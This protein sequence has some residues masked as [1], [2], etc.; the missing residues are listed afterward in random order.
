MRKIKTRIFLTALIFLILG[1]VT[2]FA[3]EIFNYPQGSYTDSIFLS[4]NDAANKK[5]IFYSFTA[6]DSAPDMPYNGGFLLS[7]LP[8]EER[9]YTLSLKISGSVYHFSYKIDRKAPLPPVKE[10]KTLDSETG[11]IFKTADRE[12]VHIYYGYDDYKS[13]QRLEWKGELIKPNA[14]SYI[15]Y[16]AEDNAGNRSTVETIMPAG[17]FSRSGRLTLNVKSPVEGVFLNTQLLFI[18]REGFEWIKYSLNGNDPLN[19]GADYTEPV[20]IRRYGTVDLKIAAKPL[21]SDQIITKDIE[22]R[23][24][25]RSPLKNIPPSGIYSTGIN[26]PGMFDSYKYCLEERTPGDSD[27][28]LK[29]S[30]TINPVYGGVKYTI[31]R[32]ND[33]QDKTEGDYRY[34]YVIDER[35]P[36]NPIITFKSRLPDEKKLDVEISGPLYSDIYYTVDGSSPGITSNLFKKTFTIDIPDNKN[37]GSIILK[38]RAISLNGKPSSVVSKIFTY[39]TQ[40][41]DTPKVEFIQNPANGIYNIDYTIGADEQLYYFV[42]RSSEIVIPQK[43]DFSPVEKERFFIDIPEGDSGKFNF[44]FAVKDSAGNWSKFSDPVE[45]KIDKSC[46]VLPEVNY[47]NG[48]LTFDDSAYPEKYSYNLIIERNGE[49]LDNREGDWSGSLSVNES[50]FSYATLLLKLECSDLYGNTSYKKYKFYITG[51]KANKETVLFAGKS[52]NIFSGREVNFTAY[53]DGVNDS[54][55]YE[56]TVLT[57]AGDD[58]TTGPIETDGRITIEGT[59]NA[60][61]DYRLDVYSLNNIDGTKSKISSYKFTIDNEKPEVPSFKGP[62]NNSIISDRVILEA[63]SDGSSTVFL[64]VGNEQDSVLNFS[65]QS[66]VFNKPL[67]FDVKNGKEKDFSL[68]ISAGDSA[69]NYVTNDNILAFTIDKKPPVI[70]EAM[71]SDETAGNNIQKLLKLKSSE[72]CTYYYEIGPAGSRISSPDT[73]SEY[74]TDSL[75]LNPADRKDGS[76]IIKVLPIDQAGNAADYPLSFYYNISRKK[77]SNNLS[78]VTINNKNTGKIYITFPS[79]KNNSL[80]YRINSSGSESEWTAYE[81]PFSVKYT[82][83]TD[84]VNIEYYLSD[85]ANNRSAVKNKIIDLPKENNSSLVSGIDNNGFYRE[86]LQLQSA[87]PRSGKI[88]RYEISTDHLLPNEVSVFSPELPETLPFRI[89]N[90]ESINFIVSIKE[91]EN[92]DDVTGGATQVLRF[93]IDKQLPEPPVISGISDGEYYLEDCTAYFKPTNDKIFYTVSTGNESEEEYKVFSQPFLISTPAGTYFSYKIKAFTQDLSGNRS[94]TKTWEITIDKEIIYVSEDGK[95]YFE[96]TRSRPFASI[97]KALEQV[98][99]SKRKTIFIQEGNYRLNSPGVIDENITLYGGFK[100]GSWQNKT[101][102]TYINIESA[103]PEDNPAFYIYGGNLTVENINFSISKETSGTVFFVNKG[104]LGIRNCNIVIDSGSLMSFLKQ[105]YGKLVLSNSSFSGTIDGQPLLYNEYGEIDINNSKFNF[106][107]NN[108]FSTLIKAE[109]CLSYNLSSTEFNISK[110]RDFTVLSFLN[111]AVKLKSDTIDIRGCGV[112]ATAIEGVGSKINVDYSKFLFDDS[113]RQS[114]AV[115]TEDCLFNFSGNTVN[116]DA[117]T[118]IIGFNLTGGESYIAENKVNCAE[119]KDFTYLYIL[120]KGKHKIETNLFNIKP[121]NEMLN[122]RTKNAQADYINNTFVFT[123]SGKSSVVF[124]PEANSMT[125]IINNIIFNSNP[126]PSGTLVYSDTKNNL[127]LKNNCLY[128]WS[129]YYSGIM[130][131][132]TLIKLDLLDGIYSGGNFSANIEEQPAVTFQ[133][134]SLY[135]LSADSKCINSGY[136]VTNIIKDNTDIDGEQRPNR[137]LNIINA[138]DIGA[139]EYY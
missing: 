113:N 81:H 73:D 57:P 13:G 76:Y 22:Y 53:P 56:L 116:L 26:I 50:D 65:N 95:D 107:S 31:L 70:E 37:A 39:D 112:G 138:Y 33:T 134:D 128:G 34:F 17:E 98:K 51:K 66:I 120:N 42:N 23:V 99:L 41:P 32:L 114:R 49:V 127:S 45:L 14:S 80:F 15:Y 28:I 87:S 124:K 75:V 30:M 60:S 137:D 96:G 132:D 104:D 117:F 135:R 72:K 84:S 7:A 86:D 108:N 105:N 27:N 129:S 136:D 21:F 24:N 77:L 90:G 78:P 29:Q 121:T 93:T 5:D 102:R 71:I 55:Y 106:N 69:G 67:I 97:N 126:V 47:S 92:A 101:G 1:S 118:G 61:V 91:F 3:D 43:N 58:I 2:V 122:L 40:I 131:A 88:L 59:E 25:T 35:F 52:E 82:S 36:A 85:S 38:A 139:D 62:A 20:E 46:P 64:N 109:N 115:V 103:F 48:V 68:K 74:F 79:E 130:N 63:E 125:R 18:D 8:G 6:D 4:V 123:G 89:S 54:L 9:L 100:K 16:Y 83:E 10:L 94:S 111:S 119:T 19:N 110:A 133:K 11:Y 12:P 44:I